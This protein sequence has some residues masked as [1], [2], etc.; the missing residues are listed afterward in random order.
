[1]RVFENDQGPQL[2]VV[3][4]DSAWP[5]AVNQD[6]RPDVIKTA[7]FELTIRRNPVSVTLRDRQGKTLIDNWIVDFTK[8]NASW[9]LAAN[10][11]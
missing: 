5:G 4:P 8:P 1:N 9:L 6:G 11:H 3:K 7:A 2:M 10:E